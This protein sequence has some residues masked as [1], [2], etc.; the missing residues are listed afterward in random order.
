MASCTQ[1]ALVMA[2]ANL[3]M[4]EETMLAVVNNN[5]T[6][7]TELVA[8][9]A[10]GEDMS[11]FEELYRRYYRRVYCLCLRMTANVADAEDLAHDV[12]LQVQRNIRSFRGEATFASWLHR[13]TVNQ[14]LMR[15]RK[16]STRCELTTEDGEM[17]EVVMPN[18]EKPSNMPIID[19]IAIACAIERLPTGYRKVFLLH[20]VD[21]YEH[22]E[23]ARI[24]GISAGTSKSQLHKARMKL[25]GILLKRAAEVEEEILESSQNVSAQLLAA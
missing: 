14:V 3:T 12:F 21:G 10:A 9:S 25:R 22:E 5:L 23:I 24:L 20:D 18:T 19:H 16:K 7:D 1:I 17:P 4:E 8:I 13:I 15:F 2:D 11:T 6:P